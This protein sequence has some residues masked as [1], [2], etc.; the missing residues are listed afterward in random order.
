MNDPNRPMPID[1]KALLDAHMPE[2]PALYGKHVNPRFA[3]AMGLIGFDRPFVRGRGPWLWDAA[4]NKYLDM[5][6]GYGVFNIGRNH[7]A[8][9]E[10]LK[11]FM[12]LEVSSLV[13]MDTPL[14]VALAAR[15]LKKRVGLGLEHVYFG[16][17]GAEANET[18]I[19]FARKTT[20]K[21]RVLH[22]SAAFHGL[23]TGALALNGSRVF[24]EG[25]GPLPPSGEV[26]FG[27]LE[28][29]E[30]EL[31]KGDVAAFFIEPVQGK[32]VRV[33]P[34]GYLAAAARLCHE[35]GA[36]MVVD[37]VQTG[38]GR[39]GRFLAIHHEEDGIHPDM[40]LMSKALSGGY[41]PVS[42]VLMS[43]RVYDAVFSSLERSVVHSSTFGKSNF[44]ATALLATLEVV[45]EEKLAENAERTGA[46]LMERLAAL[47]DRYEFLHAV[48]GR[49]LMIAID[50]GPP[51]SLKLKTAWKMVNSM[52]AEL[53][54]Q[55]ITMPLLERH[56]VLTQ[57]A[58]YN[59]HTIKL[60]PP[61]V[62]GE[63]EVEWFVKAFEDV[64]EALHRFP[65]PAWES[66]A[67]IA[68]NALGGGKRR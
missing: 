33:A 5:L 12:D 52:N 57:V 37:E 53:F 19:K 65:G 35:H 40:V 26:P 32:G 49:G 67:S 9:R 2:A 46:L 63:E 15:E 61:L 4:G 54:C 60:I 17:T 21:P 1:L 45:D 7:P 34:G 42:A 3:R 66:L 25:F 43:R 13:Q 50:F 62:I 36:L 68:R 27:D 22:A 51:K 6:S 16:S 31:G 58:G 59:M 64:M 23:T 38:V 18:A 56:R 47:V 39:C 41:V 24:R 48:R 30:N 44:A 11:Q 28:A 8:L 55:A 29:L 10:A 14:L 20:G